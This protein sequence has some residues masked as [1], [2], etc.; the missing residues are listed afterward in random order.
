MIRRKARNTFSASLSASR[1]LL[2]LT[3]IAGVCGLAFNLA[4]AEA[5]PSFGAGDA[6]STAIFSETLPLISGPSAAS[7]A[8]AAPA[9]TPAPA[10]DFVPVFPGAQGFGVDTPAGRGGQIIKVTNLNASGPGSLRAALETSGPRIIVFE[11]GGIIDLNKQKLVITE[12]FVTIAGQTAP[13]PGIT[14]VRGGMEIRTHDV[15]MKH[16]RIRMGDAGAAPGSGYEPDVST[17]GPD[18]YNIVIDH[19]S[20]AWGVDENLSASGPRFDG[21]NGTSRRLTFSNNIIAEGLYDSVHSKGIHSMGTLIHDYVTDAAIIGNL[22]AHNWERNPWFKGFATGVIVNNVIYNPGKWAMRLGY[23][24]GEWSG[25]AIQPQ[26]PKVSVVG[27]YMRHGVNTQPG[28]G[29]IGTNANNGSAYLE[30]NIALDRNDQ[31]VPI[32]FGGIEILS[33]KPSWP[34]ELTVL[35]SDEVV[36]HVV[37]HAG[38]RPKDRDSVDRRIVSDFLNRTGQ[39]VNSQDEV[40]GY[41]T[42]TPTY[43]SLEVPPSNIDEW[44]HSFSAELE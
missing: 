17:Y 4:S 15:L 37:Q 10:G 30:D 19:C 41:P 3:M 16:I 8:A 32:H 7:M 38:A 29:M 23:V 5:M 39:F 14:I 18:A 1:L 28:L 22:Y 6:N 34:A 36:D 21:P 12:P 26:G 42:A 40:G 20:F 11:V 2:T 24:P 43:R 13:S 27:N 33:S 9:E 25:Q 31:P 35:P 44:L